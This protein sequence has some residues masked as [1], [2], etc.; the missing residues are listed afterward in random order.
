MSVFLRSITLV[1]LSGVFSF[2]AFAAPQKGGAVKTGGGDF[3]LGLSLGDPTGVNGKYYLSSHTAVVGG[4]GFGIGDIEGFQLHGDFV[5][6]PVQL[7]SNAHMLLSVY[8]G[9][10]AAMVI[11]DGPNNDDFGFG[12]RAPIGVNF[13]FTRLPMDAFFEFAPGGEFIAD[14]GFRLD[15]AAGA[16]YYF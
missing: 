16:R 6:H 13:A 10:G 12:V 15:V 9:A 11:G 2:S 7:M 14:P 8:V 5:W 3:G 4:M 1:A